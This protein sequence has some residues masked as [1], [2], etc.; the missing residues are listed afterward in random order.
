M[1]KIWRFETTIPCL[2]VQVND[3]SPI[4]IQWPRAFIKPTELIEGDLVARQSKSL[5]EDAWC[6]ELHLS[7]E[8]LDFENFLTA[9]ITLY[10]VFL[11]T[12]IRANDKL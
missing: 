9:Y 5:K 3:M 2:S 11:I 1:I 6:L 8:L 10:L 12:V 7:Y 4:D